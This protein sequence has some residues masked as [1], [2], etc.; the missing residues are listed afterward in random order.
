MTKTDHF[1]VLAAAS[2]V[3]LAASL[4]MLVEPAEATFPG[5][6]G[7]IAYQGEDGGD[8]E[9]FSINDAAG[10]TPTNVTANGRNDFEAAFSPTGGEIA[11][12]SSEDGLGNDKELYVIPAAGGAPTQLTSNTALDLARDPAFSP[13]GARIAYLGV[14]NT[15]NDYEIFAAKS[16]GS[17]TPTQ[18]TDIGVRPPED[19]INSTSEFDLSW[20]PGGQ[21][22]AYMDDDGNDVEIFTTDTS[23]TGALTQLTNNTTVDYAPAWSPDGMK[24]AY[25]G[26]GPVGDTDNEVFT[27]NADGTG[28][29]TNVT[30]NNFDDGIGPRWSPDGKKIAY[31]GDGT[32][33]ADVFTIDAAGG[34][35][36][37]VADTT[38]DAEYTL[39][40][41]P[42]GARIAYANYDGNDHEIFAAK[43]DGSGM[44][45]QLTNN[46][47]DDHDPDWGRLPGSSSDTTAPTVS[48]VTPPDLKKSVP[49]RTNVTATFSE[50]VQASTIGTATFTLIRKGTTAPVGA[51][52]GYNPA[53]TKATLSPNAKLKVGKTYIATVEGGSSGVKDL[54]GNALATDRVWR[55]TIRK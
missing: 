25:R 12:S 48:S 4:M 21:K 36:T 52:V 29:P 41:S 18:L 14:D 9:I 35:P 38:G 37:K 55:F 15:D 22:I 6:N 49:P 54:A 8:Y 32:A 20:S 34:T 50:A 47:T 44:P 3:A 27:I 33:N 31:I 7:R 2:A 5:A 17:G 51:T 24:I 13:D 16:D 1:R 19:P 11:Y 43:S 40:W 53:T 10:G 45:T 28:M 46:V 26:Q 30:N 23:G 39:A 42:D